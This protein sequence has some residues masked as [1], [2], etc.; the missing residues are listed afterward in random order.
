MANLSICVSNRGRF[1]PRDK[2]WSLLRV[3]VLTERFTV[4]EG[5]SLSGPYRI[6]ES[7]VEWCLKSEARK[8]DEQRQKMSN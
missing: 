5:G 6:G 4:A 8:T 1:G 7:R 2:R 3:K